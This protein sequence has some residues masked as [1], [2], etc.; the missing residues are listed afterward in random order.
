MLHLGSLRYC[1]LT[2]DKAHRSATHARLRL[3]YLTPREVDSYNR[4]SNLSVSPGGSRAKFRGYPICS[5]NQQDLSSERPG[6]SAVPHSGACSNSCLTGIRQVGALRHQ[7]VDRHPTSI[8]ACA[9]EI[10][11]KS[12]LTSSYSTSWLVASAHRS[13]LVP[14]SLLSFAE[15][16]DCP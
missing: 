15:S 10:V 2:G 3:P 16:C 13:S 7:R 6:E 4:I 8:A 12:P 5:R 1:A 9:V 14:F 11:G